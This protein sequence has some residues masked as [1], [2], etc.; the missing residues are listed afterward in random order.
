MCGEYGTDQELQHQG[1]EALGRPHFHACIFNWDFP[2]KILWQTRDD[3]NLY[4]SKILEKLWPQGY[5]SVG[6]LTFETAAYTARYI[7]KKINGEAALDHYQRF[8][9]NTGEITLLQP[10][11]TLQSR[12]PGIASDWFKKYKSDLDKDF[13]TMRGIKMRPAKFYDRLYD[14][15]DEFGFDLIKEK[16]RIQMDPNDPENFTDRLR[17]KEKIKL[18]KLK[19][20]KRELI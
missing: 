6:A 7:M 8:D 20:L 12:R 15:I 13:I 4:R 19:Q 17:V 10:E 9:E 2:D 3:I 5:T 16:R 18:K 1:I 11:F 14:K